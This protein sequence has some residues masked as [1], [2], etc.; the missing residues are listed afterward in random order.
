VAAQSATRIV[1]PYAWGAA[2]DASGHRERLLRIA[3]GVA[4]VASFGFFL[5]PSLGVVAAATVLLY[6]ATAG[7]IPIS[8]TL[9]SMRVSVGGRLDVGRYGR[10]RL[11]GSLGFI[12]AVA[13]SGLVL[14]AAGI[15]WFP[16]LCV[17]V[18][19]VLVA[20]TWRMPRQIEPVH[21]A[22]APGGALGVLRQPAVAWFFAG[23]FLTVLAHTALYAFFSLHLDALGY[24][25]R[26]IGLLGAAGVV[27][28]VVWFAW[29][30]RWLGALSLQAWLLV[31]ALA[32]ALRFGLV[33]GWAGSIAVLLGAQLLHALTFAAQ[34][35]ACT[36][37]LTRY[38]PGR[39]RARGQA[40]YAVIGYG[41]SGVLGGLGGGALGQ[42][43]GYA[44]VFWAAAGVSLVAAAACARALA[45]DRRR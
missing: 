28:E 30:G 8:E 41:A 6:L 3:A 7:V 23:M 34:H 4:L 25:K 20:T 32:S 29:Q 44:S 14:D 35:S 19:A 17:A 13:G 45:L 26:T 33:A 37:L 9:L 21:A 38:F 24:P 5:P 10:V 18:L 36:A 2:A 16:F 11:W 40:L 42:A 27:A 43:F 22:E 39:L 1:A 15:D 12:V 31:A